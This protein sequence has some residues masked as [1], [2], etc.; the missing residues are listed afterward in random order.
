MRDGCD[1]HNIVVYGNNVDGKTYNWLTV[2]PIARQHFYL[3]AVEFCDALAICYERPLM[4][5]P[6]TCDDYS[7]PF[8]FVH[9]LDYKGGFITQRHS[10]IR[11]TLQHWHIR[12]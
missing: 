10:E 11:E 12:R 4:R 1:N 7:A 5:M 9:A 3:S 2:M 8:S 6:A